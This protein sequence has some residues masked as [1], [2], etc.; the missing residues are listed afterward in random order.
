MTE[1]VA[2]VILTFARWRTGSHRYHNDA[3]LAVACVADYNEHM[4][5]LFLLLALACAP[6]SV[7][8][9]SLSDFHLS[10][11]PLFGM[12]YGELDEYVFLKEC[13]YASDKL[14]ELNWE[15]KPL[16]YTGAQVSGSYRAWEL[17]LKGTV[18]LPGK[19]GSM[20]DSDW[21]NIQYTDA[22]LASYQTNYSESDNYLNSNYTWA[23]V[24]GYRFWLTPHFSLKSFFAFDYEYIDFTGTGGKYWYGNTIGFDSPQRY[25]PYNDYRDSENCTTGTLSGDVI[26]YK[27]ESSCLWLGG[28]A[29]AL[30]PHG[31]SGR[32]GFQLSPYIYT[33]SIDDHYMKGTEYADVCSGYFSALKLYATVDYAFTQQISLSLFGSYLFYFQPLRG[34]DYF[35]TIGSSSYTKSDDADGGASAHYADVSLSVKYTFF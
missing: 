19:T 21:L 27:R 28:E 9:V 23:L 12:K 30:F 13:S 5:K 8:S 6:L 4:K 33:V 14:S 1:K 7:F 32:L 15:I 20:Y 2:I 34:N 10:V 18:A 3:L 25:G 11:E 24:A 17:S 22:A 35:K 26:G 29:L 31:L 16:L